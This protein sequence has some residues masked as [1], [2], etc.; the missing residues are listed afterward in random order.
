MTALE[1]LDDLVRN[2]LVS[3]IFRM[4]RAYRLLFGIGEQSATLNGGNFGELFGAVQNALE[5]EAVL[6]T[7]RLYDKPN[8][9]Y[10]TRCLRQVLDFLEQR[11]T[12]LPQ[13]VEAYNTKHAL[14]LITTDADVLASVDAG[15]TDFVAKLVPLYRGILDSQDVTEKVEKLKAIRD[16]RMAHNEAATPAGPTWASLET[17]ILHAQHLVGVIGWAFFSRVYVHNGRYFLSDDAERPSRAI[18]RLAR[19][20]NANGT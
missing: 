13:V 4:E 8:R 15:T 11:A 12:E 17:L 19:R 18:V 9:R 1:E 10:P 5:L 14:E 3:D 16:K 7:A 2:G 20:L 6:A